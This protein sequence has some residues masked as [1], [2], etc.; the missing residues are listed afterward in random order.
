MGGESKKENGAGQAACLLWGGG[1]RRR[2]TESY[3]GILY[4]ELEKFGTDTFSEVKWGV[5]A[6]RKMG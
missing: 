3:F 6:K 4:R 2:H 5:R 1:W